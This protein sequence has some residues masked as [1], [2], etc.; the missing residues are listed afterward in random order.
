MVGFRP[1]VHGV[2]MPIGEGWTRRC[3]R[4][5]RWLEELAACTTASPSDWTTAGRSRSGRVSCTTVGWP[6]TS[7][8]QRPAPPVYL[9]V[10]DAVEAAYRRLRSAF[11]PGRV[12]YSVKA[13]GNLALLRRLAAIGAGFDVVSGGELLRVL[14]AGGRPDQ[15]VF[16]GVGKTAQ[17]LAVAVRSGVVLH[18]ES[19]DEL[20]ACRRWR[21]GWGRGSVRVAGQPG[22]GSRTPSLSSHR[23]RPGQVRPAGRRRGRAVS[24]G[25]GRRLPQPRPGRGP[26][27]RWFPARRPGRP[28]HRGQGRARRARSGPAVRAPPP[29]GW[30]SAAAS[31]STTTAGRCRP[32]KSSPP[33]SSL[34]AGAGGELKVEP[35]RSLV[36][37]ILAVTS[38]PVLIRRHGVDAVLD[39]HN[40][41]RARGRLAVRRPA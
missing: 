26:C 27:P 3:G 39:A 40:L 5:S 6:S 18:V 33:P 10:L 16:A 19:A 35:G 24:A 30:T 13:N 32:R 9:Y 1:G 14:R 36:A 41:A 20:A 28:G 15:T 21:P 22:R 2:L 4:C 31:R 11:R 37:K 7:W 8:L 38:L 29:P 12:L 34:V 25:R 23:P 17:E